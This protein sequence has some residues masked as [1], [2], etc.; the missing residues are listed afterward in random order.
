M[1]SVFDEEKILQ[2]V[3]PLVDKDNLWRITI[4]SGKSAIS[5]AMFN[6]YPGKNNVIFYYP[7]LGMVY[8]IYKNGDDWGMV[9]DIVFTLIRWISG[10][11][12]IPMV[13]T[14]NSKLKLKKRMSLNDR[15]RIWLG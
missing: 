3:Y 11:F 7:W 10:K 9:Y 15:P 12:V 8:T 13:V 4:F 2:I 14:N 5:I 1:D 6:S